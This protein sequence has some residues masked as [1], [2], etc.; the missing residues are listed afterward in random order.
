VA[1]FPVSFAYT[2]QKQSPYFDAFWF[3]MTRL[4]ENG[5]FK[6][7]MD[8]YETQPQVCPDYSGQPLAFGQCFTAFIFLICGIVLGL[9]WLV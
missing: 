5:A 1:Y 2:I 9:F 6:Q 4:K 3:H 7:I 8:S